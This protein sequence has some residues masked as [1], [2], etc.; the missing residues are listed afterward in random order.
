MM[1][2]TLKTLLVGTLSVLLAVS[3]Y[4]GTV[5]AEWFNSRSP[6]SDSSTLK[7]ISDSLENISNQMS[8]LIEIERQ[9]LELERRAAE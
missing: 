1:R 8:Q 4:H 7:S 2:N 9:R 5:H 6:G 3:L